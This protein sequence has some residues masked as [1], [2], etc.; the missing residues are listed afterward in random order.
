MHGA[1]ARRT[2]GTHAHDSVSYMGPD[3]DIGC[4][5]NINLILLTRHL[6]LNLELDFLID[7]QPTSPSDPPA[8][9]PL[10]FWLQMNLGPHLEF[11]VGSGD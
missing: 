2:V 8:S 10:S 4:S 11:Y 9:S 1:W 7:W 5:V 6:S 3:E